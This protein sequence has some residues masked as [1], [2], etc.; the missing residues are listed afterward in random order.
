MSSPLPALGML[1]PGFLS[2]LCPAV[3]I[4]VKGVV[5]GSNEDSPIATLSTIVISSPVVNLFWSFTKN[6]VVPVPESSNDECVMSGATG[7]VVK[8][9]LA[10][11]KNP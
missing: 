11:R 7:I 9:A 2:I 5:S 4:G 8:S 6:T 1:S 3:G 10:I